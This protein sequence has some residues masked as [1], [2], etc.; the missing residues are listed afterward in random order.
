MPEIDAGEG[1]GR[2][3]SYSLAMVEPGDFTLK[4]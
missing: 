2:E 4:I 3:K 1:R